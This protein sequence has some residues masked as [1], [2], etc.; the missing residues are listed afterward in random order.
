MKTFIA[1]KVNLL[2]SFLLIS[3]LAIAGY[4]G[5]I[6]IRSTAKV[7]VPDFLGKNREEAVE[8]CGQ[9]DEQYSCEFVY[10][11]SSSVEKDHIF[12]QSLNS[13]SV[14][15]DKLIIHVS[16]ELIKQIEL[17]QMNDM[18]K[19]D[20]EKWA[21]DNG[22]TNLTFKEENSDTVAKGNVIRIE[23]TENISRDTEIIVYISLGKKDAVDQPIEIKSGEYVNLSVSRFEE[24]MKALGL[25]PNHDT[26]RDAKSESV[27]KGNVVWHGSGTYEK[28]E[29]INY[30]VCLEETKGSDKDEIYISKDKYVGKTES[31]FKEIAA[32][33]GLKPVH[34]SERDA[35]SDNYEKGTVIT[36]G[37]GYYVLNEDFNYGLSLGKKESGSDEV[38]VEYGTYIGKTEE[39][40]KKIASNLNLIANHKSSK[41]GYSDTISKGSVIWHGSGTYKCNDESDPFN[42]G[43]SLGKKSDTTPSDSIVISA[44]SYI[45]KSESEFCSA[46][47]DLGLKP[48]H[49]T[50]RDDYSDTVSEGC[51]VWHGS[52]TY[53]KGEDFNYGLSLGK[54]QTETGQIMRPEKYQVGDTF[55]ST[56]EKM[57]QYLSVF[58]NVQYIGVSSTKGVGRLEMIEVGSY[59]SGYSAGSYPIDT[60]IKVYIV[61]NQTN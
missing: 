53:T 9:L 14:L 38:Y 20:I 50:D 59:G 51:I 40:F 21:N 29:T 19:E 58:T 2:L 31:E 28:D 52:G 26:S 33:L 10:E 36:H 54:K 55:E 5:Y 8:W 46:A 16:S 47:Q 25:S 32:D 15:K 6:M 34:L 48:Y 17:P 24:Q 12:Q 13:G 49:N 43:L 23:P 56:K 3:M 18:K 27:S 61:N 41:D 30:G 22:V 35:Y 42:Y 60:Q 39:E 11:P 45:G 37:N 7:V 4:F 57:Q 1:N 44:G